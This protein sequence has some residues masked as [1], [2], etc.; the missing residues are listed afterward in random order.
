MET[1]EYQPTVENE[2][3]NDP[4]ALH[5]QLDAARRDWAALS[6]KRQRRMFDRRIHGYNQTRDTYNELVVECQK[7]DLAEM[8]E[9]EPDQ[10]QQRLMVAEYWLNEQNLLREET[11][12]TV[13]GK[14]TWKFAHAFA[15]FLNSGSRRTRM[16]K[17]IALG[18]G[19]GIAG[20]MLGGVLGAATIGTGIVAAGRFA[21]GYFARHTGGMEQHDLGAEDMLQQIGHEDLDEAEF[22]A[23]VQDESLEM[24]NRDGKKEQSKQRRAFAWGAGSVAV[25][26]VLGAAFAGGHWGGV[27]VAHAETIGSSHTDIVGG[28]IHT[29]IPVTVEHTDISTVSGH[30]DVGVD[31]GHTDVGVDTQAHTDIETTSG[32]VGA[33]TE[34]HGFVVEK[35]HGIS[36]EICDYAQSLGYEGLSSDDSYKMY[37]IILEEHGKD[38]II[39]VHGVSSDTYLHGSDVRISSPGEANWRTGVS[40]DL[41]KLFQAHENGEKLSLSTLEHG[42]QGHVDVTDVTDANT[43]NATAS[44][45]MHATTSSVTDHSDIGTL[46]HV[47]TINVTPEAV[48]IWNGAPTE[49]VL[50][51]VYGGNISDATAYRAINELYDEFG[52]SGVFKDLTL[53][54]HSPNNIWINENYGVAELTTQ[55]KEYMQS[56]YDL[57]A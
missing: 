36:R 27:S 37:Q 40:E 18:F 12:N 48:H 55:A 47:E 46:E 45:I 51:G 34:Q 39:D 33:E 15:N 26:A 14:R 20:S 4:E 6:A 22:Q 32:T 17:G 10:T 53:S 41:Q 21:R 30:T 7:L 43:P 56:H 1:S 52:G 13:E 2:Y 44:D 25:G 24:F 38:G 31:T 8:L 35:G 5:D 54:E 19:I 28:T 50:Q 3:R 42:S 11:K 23:A 49:Q 57:A 16:I 9:N 29:D